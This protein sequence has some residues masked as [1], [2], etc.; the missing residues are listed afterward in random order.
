MVETT[1][2]PRLNGPYK[3]VGEV[4]LVDVDGK[5]FVIASRP[6]RPLALCR[7]GASANKPFCDAMHKR[8]DFQAKTTVGR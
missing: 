7:C 5:E 6:G 3:V 4:R 8:I 2:T 1:I